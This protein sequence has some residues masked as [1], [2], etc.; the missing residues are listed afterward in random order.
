MTVESRLA[1]L[2]NELKALKQYA[3]VSIGALQY[4]DQT[5]TESY[6]GNFDTG[7]VDLVVA[8]LAATFT[9]S[10]GSQTTPLVDFAFETSITPT[11]QDYMRD[12]GVEITGLDP[13][14][15]GEFFVHCYEAGTTDDSVTVFIDVL[16][17]IAPYAG[18]TATLSATVQAIS[19]VNGNLTLVRVI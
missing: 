4:P 11:Y 3:P 16:N 8:R 15:A 5:P 19:P 10:D 13:N 12:R 2:E 14:E 18:A 6:S 1:G 7:G 9:R 17:A